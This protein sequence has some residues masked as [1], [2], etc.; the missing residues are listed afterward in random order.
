MSNLATMM[1]VQFLKDLGIDRILVSGGCAA[2]SPAIVEAIR[3]CFSGLEV[4]VV[5]EKATGAS[6][7][8]GAAI[9]AA[10]M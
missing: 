4:E 2:R 1:P 6:S 3:K 9:F 8:M 10:R 5:D 7:A